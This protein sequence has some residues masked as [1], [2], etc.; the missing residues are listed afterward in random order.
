MAWMKIDL[1]AL[2]AR[3]E[4]SSCNGAGALGTAVTSTN[5]DDDSFEDSLHPRTDFFQRL[6]VAFCWVLKAVTM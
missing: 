3:D 4:K 2:L 1:C 6:A 5:A